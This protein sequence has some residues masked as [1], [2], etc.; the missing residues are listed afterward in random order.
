[1]HDDA[2]DAASSSRSGF[3]VALRHIEGEILAG[4]YVD[5]T[6]LPPE[7]E[8]AAQ[9]GVSRGAVREA[10]RVMQ[11]QGILVSTTGPGNGT[12]VK[13]APV[14]AIGRILRLHLALDSVSFADVTD[15]RVALERGSVAA[16]ARERRPEAI[17]R[18]QA[19]VDEMRTL[20]QPERFNDLDT[21]FHIALA[22]CGS[23]RLMRDLTI[24]IRW[25]VHTPLRLKELEQNDWPSMHPGLVKQHQGIIDAVR[26]GDEERAADLVEQHIR[27]SYADLL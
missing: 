10:I 3:E 7:R 6:R 27:E 21:Q 14:D 19:I 8:L 13:T 12:R 24:A 2:V 5:G 9:L 1:M 11:T 23:N 26:D 20:T 15:T 17:A 16:A 4:R 18:A 25:S 22:E